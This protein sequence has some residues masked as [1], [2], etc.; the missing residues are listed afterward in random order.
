MKNWLFV[1]LSLV[2]CNEEDLPPGTITQKVS[3]NGVMFQIYLIANSF[4]SID[5]LEGTFVVTNFADST[6]IWSFSAPSPLFLRIK[7]DKG[8]VLATSIRKDASL[9][10]S[11]IL[12][13]G[14]NFIF[15]IERQDFTRK[16]VRGKIILEVSLAED[17]SPIVSMPIEID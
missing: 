14:E 5:S 9:G 11:L 12:N 8:E 4:K 6:R 2:A 7:S 17:R 16:S 3:D 10:S 13:K 15:E 1:L